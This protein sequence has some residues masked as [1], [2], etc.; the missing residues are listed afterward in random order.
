VPEVRPYVQGERVMLRLDWC[1]HEAAAFACRAWHYSRSLPTPPLVK[2]GVWERGEFIG[3]VLFT[4]GANRH[5]GS[6]FGLAQ[7][8]VAEL[9]RVALREHEA[10]VSRIVAVA[11]RLLR[12]HCP[13][14]RLLVSFADPAQGHVGAIY[15]SMNWVYLGVTPPSRVFVDGRGRRWHPRM[16]SRTGV[17]RIYGEA[18]RV[19]RI[20]DCAVE[21]T[22]GKHRYALPLDEDMR[23]RLAAMAMPYP[24]RERSAESGTAGSTRRG[25]C[26]ATRSLHDEE[27]AHG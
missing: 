12:R 15:Q 25:R 5:L 10:P 16:V 23:A 6:A 8:E 22:P 27:A 4:R 20:A 18:R 26:D 19:M 2:V 7:T 24:K 1:S 9:S 13:G 3:V 11:I 17:K 14:L 21:R